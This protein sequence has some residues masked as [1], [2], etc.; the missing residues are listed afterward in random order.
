V[1]PTAL[2]RAVPVG[3]VEVG[4]GRVDLAGWKIRAVR[5][6]PRAPPPIKEKPVRE[7]LVERERDERLGYLEQLA[8]PLAERLRRP[9]DQQAP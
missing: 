6:R 3:I 7:G 2:H 5:A 1:G 8:G 4:V 9:G